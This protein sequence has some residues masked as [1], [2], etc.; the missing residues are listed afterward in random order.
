[1]SNLAIILFLFSINNC[2]YCQC[3]TQ[4]QK[5]KNNLISVKKVSFWARE[6][7]STLNKW[8]MLITCHTTYLPTYLPPHTQCITQKKCTRVVAAVVAAVV[9]HTKKVPKVQAVI[10][11]KN[12]ELDMQLEWKL[13]LLSGAISSKSLSPTT[14]GQLFLAD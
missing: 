14:F 3:N 1:M 4:R 11:C 6:R 8:L 5:S 13:L 7:E 10:M 12:V 9:G 2:T